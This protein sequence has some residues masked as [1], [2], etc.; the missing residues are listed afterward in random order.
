MI[1]I[2][3]AAAVLSQPA[4][5][6][7][8]F[9]P[10]F[11]IGF[12]FGFG[13]PS[14]SDEDLFAEEM[15]AAGVPFEVDDMVT[16][17]SIDVTIDASRSFKV[18][19]GLGF[20]SFDGAYTDELDPM[21]DLFLAILTLGFSS[22]FDSEE[23]VID[24]ADS[25]VEIE[26]EGY[27]VI[28]RSPGASLSAGG[29]PVFTFVSRSLESPLTSSERSGSSIGF[30]GSLRVEQEGDGR[31]IGMPLRLFAQGGY[32]YSNTSL[33]GAEDFDLDFSGPYLRAGLA[34]QFR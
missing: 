22:M 33:D 30:M 28:S 16:S 18:R 19:G 14:M 27:Y 17:G 2:L 5:Y 7:D 13:F 26:T 11:K 25:Y 8:G 3:V 1:A 31:F 12:G 15:E 21:A 23:E 24:L 9:D 6:D 10:G 20:G 32:R 4:G 34:L 29:G